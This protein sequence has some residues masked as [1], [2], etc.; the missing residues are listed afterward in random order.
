ML[1][2]EIRLCQMGT[3]TPL[4][5]LFDDTPGGPRNVAT[6]TLALDGLQRAHGPDGIEMEG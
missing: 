2:L 4:A 6:A 3:A 5:T 1:V